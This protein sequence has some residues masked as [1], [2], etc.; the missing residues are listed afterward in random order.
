M[1]I[2]FLLDI[3]EVSWYRDTANGG[4]SIWEPGNEQV[5]VNVTNSITF[6]IVL[7]CVGYYAQVI[8]YYFLHI[9]ILRGKFKLL[10]PPK[11]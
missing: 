10:L 9:G 1:P 5:C 7:W 11:F 3:V 6:W 8:S 2:F 4:F